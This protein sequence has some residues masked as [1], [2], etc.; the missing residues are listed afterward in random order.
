MMPL[1]VED[2]EG[3][4][5]PAGKMLDEVDRLRERMERFPPT[6]LL[7]SKDAFVRGADLNLVGFIGCH[8]LLNRLGSGTC[9]CA[10]TDNSYRIDATYPTN[11][12]SGSPP[13]WNPVRLVSATPFAR[14]MAWKLWPISPGCMSV[15]NARSSRCPAA[16]IA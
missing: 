12:R 14:Q 3:G 9:A 8:H 10:G 4:F 11:F 6:R 16:L 15:L 1:R 13:N 5:N 7:I 2:G